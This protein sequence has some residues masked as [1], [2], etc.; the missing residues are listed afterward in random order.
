[1]AL[2]WVMLRENAKRTLMAAAIALPLMVGLLISF[3]RGAWLS[4]MPSI[5]IVVAIVLIKSR[6]RTHYLRFAT[7]GGVGIIVLIAA[8]GLATQ[9]DDQGHEQ[10][11]QRANVD[12]SDDEG[13]EGR[14]GG[15]QKARALIVEHPFGIG[16]H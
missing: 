12:Q 13:P 2:V 1:V 14:V 15:Q 4:T 7:V 8:V 6:R 16:T 5:A 9:L 11:A 10:L 3:S